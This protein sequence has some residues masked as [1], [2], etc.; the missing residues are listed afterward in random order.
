MQKFRTNLLV[1]LSCFLVAILIKAKLPANS[2]QPA[3]PTNE[4]LASLPYQ[5]GPYSGT[6]AHG[7]DIKGYVGEVH[8][9]YRQSQKNPIELLAFSTPVNVHGPENCLPYLGW[10]LIGRERRKL[11]AN[12]AIELQTVI[13]VSDNSSEHPIACGFYW[14]R[15]NRATANLF[16]DWLQQRWATIT[17]SMQ[18]AELVSIC[19]QMDDLHQAGSANER[20]YEFANDIEPYFYR[21]SARFAESGTGQIN[22]R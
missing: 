14:R 11:H 1:I 8:R 21:S 12:P 13:A 5:V 4:T 18:D 6:E 3:A 10:S 20:I 22:G 17:Q 19:T 2:G 9:I 16:I 15:H 7:E